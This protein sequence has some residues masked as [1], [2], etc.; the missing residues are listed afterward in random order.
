MDEW[1]NFLK[2]NSIKADTTAPGLAEAREKLIYAN[3]SKEERLRY[4]RHIESLAN[5]KEAINESR[6]E[7]WLEGLAEGIEK[8]MAEGIEKGI[9]QAKLETAR[10]LKAINLPTEQIATATGLTPDEIEKA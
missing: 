10:N 6:E 8:G 9:R 7:G 5:E 3:M 4:D 1:M 2:N